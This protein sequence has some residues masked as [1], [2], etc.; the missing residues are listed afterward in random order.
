M[1]AAL[2]VGDRVSITATVS[3]AQ[4]LASGNYKGSSSSLWTLQPLELVAMAA[5]FELTMAMGSSREVC[6]HHVL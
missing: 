6:S 5:K 1:K 4:A 3:Q 2:R